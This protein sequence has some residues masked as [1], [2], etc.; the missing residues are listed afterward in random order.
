MLA[1]RYD[2]QLNHACV[3]VVKALFGDQ[4][5]KVALLCQFLR[6]RDMPP[7][8]V[9]A[10]HIQNLALAIELLHRLPDFFPRA[11]AVNVVHLIE[12]NVIGFEAAQAGFA[13]T[14]DVE[15]G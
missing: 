11:F 7:C 2:F 1:C 13:G 5:H 15:R 9:A 6:L 10:A 8:E 12:V 14:L 4:P 3:E